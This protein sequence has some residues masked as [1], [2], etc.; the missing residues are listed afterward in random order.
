MASFLHHCN[1]YSPSCQPAPRGPCPRSLAK[2]GMSFPVSPGPSVGPFS[3]SFTERQRAHIFLLSLY[4]VRFPTSHLPGPSVSLKTHSRSEHLQKALADPSRLGW[5]PFPLWLQPPGPL[6]Y[7]SAP[8]TSLLSITCVSVWP[9]GL[10][11][12]WG[13]AFFL[14]APTFV[15]TAVG[16]RKV[17]VPWA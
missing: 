14:P 8:V 5:V 13:Q 16:A 3:L 2:F 7:A 12:P 1:Y 10:C 15:H 4:T 6:L 11:A 9:P 17:C